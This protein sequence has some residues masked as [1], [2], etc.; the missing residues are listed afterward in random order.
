MLPTHL[1]NSQS[2]KLCPIYSVCVW[3]G[4]EIKVPVEIKGKQRRLE[5]ETE[6]SAL[7]EAPELV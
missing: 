5:W 4:A 1:C 2:F 3:G 6:S 7:A